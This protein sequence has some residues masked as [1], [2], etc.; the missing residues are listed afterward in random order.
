MALSKS[1][2]LLLDTLKAHQ[3]LP[4]HIQKTEF[5]SV[6]FYNIFDEPLGKF[7]YY[8]V[9]TGVDQNEQLALLKS[10]VEHFERLALTESVN[11]TLQFSGYTSSDGFAAFPT[12]EL[13]FEIT[14][15]ENALAEAIERY[16][17]TY[18]WDHETHATI[19]EIELHDLDLS[20]KHL[21]TQINEDIGIEK[22]FHI[23]PTVVNYANFNTSILFVKLK[24]GGFISGGACGLDAKKTFFRA[25]SELLRHHLAYLKYLELDLNPSTFYEERLI[26]FAKGFGNKLVESRLNSKSGVAIELP[27]LMFDSGVNYSFADVVYVHRCLFE[28]Q[29]PFVG[30]ALERLCL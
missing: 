18:W 20:V 14:A 1:V 16:V 29:A 13:N 28:N 25:A 26:Y 7:I 6:Y 9:A 5:K 23:N 11:I 4:K 22:F 24:S 3:I 12:S 17:W 8:N 10:L 30:G 2:I 27:D 21:I 19:K 15:R